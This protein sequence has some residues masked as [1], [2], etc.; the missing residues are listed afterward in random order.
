MWAECERREGWVC[1]E[2]E[3]S[4]GGVWARRGRS[5]SG[6][7]APE[8]LLVFFSFPE[9]SAQDDYGESYKKHAEC[10]GEEYP[11]VAIKTQ[12]GRGTGYRW[13]DAQQNANDK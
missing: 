1:A 6:V 8:Q 12:V 13:L 5:V 11:A 2:C 4:S 3:R 10:N 7:R 9:C